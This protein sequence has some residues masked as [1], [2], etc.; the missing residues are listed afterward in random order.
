[1]YDSSV[2]RE[3]LLIAGYL[4]IATGGYDRLSRL[5]NPVCEEHSFK[6]YSMVY[7]RV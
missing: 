5:R 7:I 4:S 6:V 1:M 2:N 3:N